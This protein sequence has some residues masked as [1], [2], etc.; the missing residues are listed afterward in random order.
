M[1]RLI[2][3]HDID[4][5]SEIMS[6]PDT[7]IN[8]IIISNVRKLDEENEL[9]RFV[10]EIISD[11]NNTP[12]GPTEIAD[13]LTSHVHVRGEKQLV[14]FVLKGKSFQKVSSKDVTHQFAKLRQIPNLNLMVFGA[15]GHIQDDAQ[16]D[17]VQTAI[18][19]NYNYLIIDAHDWARL[20]IAYGKI[21]PKDGLPYDCN[22]FCSNGHLHDKSIKLEMEVREQAKYTILQQS[23]LSHS[24]AKRYSAI[25]LLDKHYPKD[26]IREI[27][28][29]VTQKMRLSNYY[30][31]ERI[32][33]RWGKNP[34]HVVWLYLAFDVED[35]QNA[36]WFCRTCWIDS[37]LPKQM[38][39]ISL[40][41]N[42][43]Y[44]DIDIL[45]NN[46][47]KIYKNIFEKY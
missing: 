46:E 40:K 42:E 14:A 20:F 24:G 30:R 36:N 5:F 19:A 38:Q 18:D 34:A 43:K 39:P 12:H 25:V 45:W 35:V 6:I 33:A 32:K 41:G 31:N 8:S 11:P 29:K 4:E 1:G 2:K 10:R 16:R 3:I 15:V 7:A 9:E 44:R 47:Y 17:F 37:S 27:I 26:V 22:G 28:Y 23:D 13:I 21:C